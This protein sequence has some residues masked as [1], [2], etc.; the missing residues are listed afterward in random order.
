MRFVSMD[1]VLLQQSQGG[2]IGRV[3]LVAGIKNGG[4]GVTLRDCNHP[5]PQMRNG[6]FGASAKHCSLVYRPNPI[7]AILEFIANK[8]VGNF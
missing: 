4:K 3:F 6:T 7:K 2:W 5:I 8:I 1:R